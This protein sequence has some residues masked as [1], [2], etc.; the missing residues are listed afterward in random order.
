MVIPM[1]EKDVTQKNFETYN[2]VVAD[3]VNGSLFHGKE[4]IKAD[5]LIDAQPF[6]QYKA[7][8]GT[9]HEQERDVAKYYINANCNIRIALIGFENPRLSH[10]KYVTISGGE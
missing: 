6:S 5:G 8:A 3:I 10:K 4:F 9:I 7:D 2:D 1:G